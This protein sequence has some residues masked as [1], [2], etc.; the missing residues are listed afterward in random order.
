MG[1]CGYLSDGIY[2]RVHLVRAIVLGL[3]KMKDAE[4]NGLSDGSVRR[5]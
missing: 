5:A 1:S 3:N 2:M 4:M